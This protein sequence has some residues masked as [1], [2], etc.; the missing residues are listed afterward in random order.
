MLRANHAV[1][2]GLRA[3][4]RNPELSFWKALAD[5]AGSL[6][7]LLPVVLAS[8]LIF[9]ADEL[10]AAVRA[11]RV[12]PWPVAGGVLAALAA[13]FTGGMLF[14][15]GALPLLAAD[16]EMDRRPPAGNF[17]LLAGKGFAR[18][19]SAGFAAYAVGLLFSL[20]C[21]AALV[22][23]LPAALLHPSPALFAGVAVV[24]T[25]AI[26]GGVIVD[27]LARL[28][29]VR[30]AAFGEGA[31]AA[32]PKAASLLGARLGGLLVVTVAF[33]FLEMLAAAGAATF[34]GAVSSSSFFDPDVELLALA[35][36]A[37]IGLAFAAVFAW[38]EVGRMGAIAAI[39]LDA[40]GLI[41]PPAPPPP[42][43][44]PVPVAEP[45]VEALPVEDAPE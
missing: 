20:A 3:A 22:A 24:G 11:L 8:L 12:V 2:L 45:V 44:P 5:Q 14:W 41:A 39:A 6:L 35:P 1:R 32:L 18:V 21:G 23:A 25:V 27:L 26:V 16:A 9:G 7:A 33:F 34:S 30:A 28:W 19:F 15:A 36:R 37:A 42:P 10:L 17:W 38:L 13:S 31:T 4:S 43:E 40:E 29:L